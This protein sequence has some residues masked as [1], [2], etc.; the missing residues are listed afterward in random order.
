MTGYKYISPAVQLLDRTLPYLRD[1]LRGDIESGCKLVRNMAGEIEPDLETLD[2]DLREDALNARALIAEVQSFLGYMK[3][4][5]ND[6]F[7]EMIERG[8]PA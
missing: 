3:P 4:A 2:D 8:L 5:S 6:W 7:D 1:A